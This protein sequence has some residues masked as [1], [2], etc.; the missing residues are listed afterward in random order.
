KEDEEIKQQ[1]VDVLT[2]TGSFT[3]ETARVIVNAVLNVSANPQPL[4]FGYSTDGGKSYKPAKTNGKEGRQATFYEFLDQISGYAYKATATGWNYPNKDENVKF[5]I[6]NDP[7]YGYKSGSKQN[8]GALYW[9]E[10]GTT[11]A[12]KSKIVFDWNPARSEGGGQT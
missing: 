2:K 5:S 8:R 7:N 9:A 6:Y 4:Y 12:D 11:S 1:M 3:D 10:S